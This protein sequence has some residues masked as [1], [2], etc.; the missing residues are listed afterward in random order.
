MGAPPRACCTP[1]HPTQAHCCE[2]LVASRTLY[3]QGEP[4]V[5]LMELS[6]ASF[7]GLGSLGWGTSNLNSP[8]Y[9]FLNPFNLAVK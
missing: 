4:I 7:W 1:L 5:K 8:A 2:Q 3:A 9:I 6:L